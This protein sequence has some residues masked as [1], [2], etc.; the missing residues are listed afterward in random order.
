MRHSEPFSKRTAG[1]RRRDERR[2]KMEM[3]D[4]RVDDASARAAVPTTEWTP[5]VDIDH[6]RASLVLLRRRVSWDR[7][8]GFG[9]EKAR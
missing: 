9:W 7:A 8:D 4:A 5:R 1:Q 2:F 3:R 6:Y